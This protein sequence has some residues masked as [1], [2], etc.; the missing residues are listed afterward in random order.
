MDPFHLEDYFAK[1]EF[2]A[3][4][5]LGSSDAQTLTMKE[6]QCMEDPECAALWENL[7][8]ALRAPAA[9]AEEEMPPIMRA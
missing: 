5:L 1:Y 8:L 9:C 3:K 7:D 2:S 4:Y 6:L